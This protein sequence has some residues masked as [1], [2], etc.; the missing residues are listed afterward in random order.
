MTP[1][2]NRLSGVYT[3]HPQRLWDGWQHKASLE[4]EEQEDLLKVSI[5]RSKTHRSP[6]SL[7]PAKKMSPS[8]QQKTSGYIFGGGKT[9]VL[10]VVGHVAEAKGI[11]LAPLCPS[12]LLFTWLSTSYSQES[13]LW[14]GE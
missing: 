6:P 1:K 9:K 4:V 8:S 14:T 11:I 12:A 7:Y 3:R 10:W 13:A 2:A 5:K